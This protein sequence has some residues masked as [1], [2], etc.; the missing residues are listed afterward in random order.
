MICRCRYSSTLV[1]TSAVKRPS[2]PCTI[3]EV[4]DVFRYLMSGIA[5]CSQKLAYVSFLTPPALP[6]VYVEVY[7][8]A[9]GAVRCSAQAE[10][11]KRRSVRVEEGSSAQ[12]KKCGSSLSQSHSVASAIS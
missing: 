12:A 3:N 4:D 1:Q 2:S 8:A 5:H 11:Q 7:C 6:L 9:A 10:A